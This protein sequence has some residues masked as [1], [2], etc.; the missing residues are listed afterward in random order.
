MWLEQQ[1]L[2]LAPDPFRREGRRAESRGTAPRCCVKCQLESGRRTESRA[3]RADCRRRTSEDR[4]RAA[5]RREI[6]PAV[7]RILVD[8][9]QRIPG[10]GVDREVA[11]AGRFRDRHERIAANLEALVP[12]AALRFAPRE[13]DVDVADAAVRD[14][15]LVDG[16][17]VADGLDAAERREQDGRRSSA[18]PNTSMSMSLGSGSGLWAL[19]CEL[20]AWALALGLEYWIDSRCPPEEGI[21]DKPP[22][23]SARPPASRRARVRCRA[24]TGARHAL[25]SRVD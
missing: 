11:P 13:C 10:N 3:G 18:M 5:R 16:K 17:A 9:G 21:A 7:E 2:D 12:A 14:H 4:P 6:A 25:R 1:F 20:W 15:Q 19:G 8:V 24:I 23:I 22:T